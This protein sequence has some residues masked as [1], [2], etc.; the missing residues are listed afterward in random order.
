MSL[1]KLLGDNGF[2]SYNK[3]IAKNV[4]VY[5]AIV[6]GELCS[7]ADLFHYEEFYFSQKKIS[8]DTGLSE[9]QIREAIETLASFGFLTVTRKGQPCKNW[10]FL[11]EETIFNYLKQFD[12]KPQN[13]QN[14]TSSSAKTEHLDKQNLPN[15]NC[16]NGTSSS[17][18]SAELLNNNNTEVTIQSN[19]TNSKSHCRK[20][21]KEDNSY[22]QEFYNTIYKC[23][24]DNFSE[25]F[26]DKEKPILNY[27]AIKKRIKVSFDLYGFGKVLEAVKESKNHSWLVSKGYNIST[28]FSVWEIAKLV[29]KTYD[30]HSKQNGFQKTN[31]EDKIDISDLAFSDEPFQQEVAV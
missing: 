26:P 23:Y 30:W 3:D 18:N 21:T 24:F 17:A 2:I 11:K 5:E 22:P 4:G 8:N 29:N 6:L 1:L 28:I 16:Q 14:G 19:N 12:S 20:T 7:I 27:N 25:L 9:K 13:C 31:L 10:Y 15:K